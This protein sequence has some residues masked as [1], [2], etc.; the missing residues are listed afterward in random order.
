MVSCTGNLP[1]VMTGDS[2]F[3]VTLGQESIYAFTVVDEGNFTV[4]VVEGLPQGAT[5]EDNGGGEYT[6]RW[7]LTNTSGSFNPLSFQAVDGEGAA[8]LLSPQLE[9]CLCANGGE[10]TLD[11]V[12]DT[13]LPVV[14][15]NCNCPEGEFGT[16]ESHE[17][18]FFL[19]CAMYYQKFTSY[20]AAYSGSFCEED[21]NGCSEIECFEGVECL[22]MAAPGVGAMC[23]PCPDGFT[24][25]G[26][27]C[28][29]E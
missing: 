9:A 4:E 1:P 8:S 6:F 21:R 14:I 29:G 5:L 12:L 2:T 22:D 16:M 7:T 17:L 27:K 23:G 28:S 15:L 20:T 26:E 19:V 18:N 11:G 13:A 25:N 3:S 10:C 24:G